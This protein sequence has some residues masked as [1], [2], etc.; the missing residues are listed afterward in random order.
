MIRFELLLSE[1]LVRKRG[2]SHRGQRGPLGTTAAS[3]PVPQ[4]RHRHSGHTRVQATPPLPEGRHGT[5]GQ[6]S[7]RST[8]PRKRQ[9]LNKYLD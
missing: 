4:S 1:W 3:L 7:A 2:S 6:L 5:T 9:G 8:E